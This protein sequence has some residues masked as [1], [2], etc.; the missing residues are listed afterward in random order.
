MMLALDVNL[1]TN[2]LQK[3]SLEEGPTSTSNIKLINHDAG[4]KLSESAQ[5]K[6]G[7]GG[8]KLFTV[9]L[10]SDTGAKT[11]TGEFTVPSMPK[12]TAVTKIMCSHKKPM[13]LCPL[14]DSSV[15]NNQV[16]S[17]RPKKRHC[18]S[19]SVPQETEINVPPAKSTWQPQGSGLWKPVAMTMRNSSRTGLDGKWDVRTVRWSPSDCRNYEFSSLA[20][21]VQRHMETGHITPEDFLTPPESPVPRPNSVYSDGAISPFTSDSYTD[22]YKVNHIQEFRNRS[23]SV[24]DKISCSSVTYTGSA[25][26]VHSM[27]SSVPSSPH[28]RYRIPRCRS[29]PSFYDRKSGRRRRRDCRPTL[30]FN[31]MTETAYGHPRRSDCLATPNKERLSSRFHAELENAMSL[32]P[33]ASSPRDSD[34]PIHGHIPV[35]HGN[36]PIHEL[37]SNIRDNVSMLTTAD[38]EMGNCGPV[39][40]LGDDDGDETDMEVFQLTEE[41]DLEQIENH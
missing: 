19:I 35:K 15:A 16:L 33:I 26:N 20:P 25:S 34:V 37:E 11:K 30:N 18:R 3:Q 27:N 24:E 21:S 39:K 1:L 10:G 36:S 14:C 28:H 13:H 32:M 22:Y 12:S 29:Q 8:K 4:F 7:A 6:L 2:K 23:L 9:S 40:L 41:L 17:D 31:K 5:A 38:D